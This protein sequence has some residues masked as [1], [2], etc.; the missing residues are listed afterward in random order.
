MG[1]Y[2]RIEWREATRRYMET[3]GACEFKAFQQ[4]DL[5]VL[6]ST[7]AGRI[8]MSISHKTRNPTWEEIRDARYSL[9]PLA[10]HFVMA[11]PPP[12]C[13]VNV[14]TRAFHLWELRPERTEEDL[15]R[16]FEGG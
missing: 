15:I 4:G 8:H 10:K 16:V 13:Y 2:E 11:L 7:D 5:K 6:I 12:Q 1:R 9:L 14:H 3:I